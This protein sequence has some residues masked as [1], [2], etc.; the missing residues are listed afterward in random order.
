MNN[1]QKSNVVSHVVQGVFFVLFLAGA[2]FCIKYG[3]RVGLSRQVDLYEALRNFSAGIFTV[4]GIWMALICPDA[5]QKIFAGKNHDHDRQLKRVKIL[6]WPLL[7]SALCIFAAMSAEVFSSALPSI[8]IFKSHADILKR[9]SFLVIFVLYYIE[10]ACLILALVPAIF[11]TDDI[12]KAI[13]QRK[14][15]D[16]ITPKSLR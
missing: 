13:N 7:F 2:S 11:I 8:S 10:I 12:Q 16:G 1:Q 14:A 15:S 3:S 4:V 6:I 5:V 9:A